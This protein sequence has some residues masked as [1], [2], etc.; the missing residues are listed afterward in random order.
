M[1]AMEEKILK[2]GEVFPGNILKV[3]SFLNHRIDVEF[4]MEMGKDIAAHFASSKPDKILTVEASGIAIAIAAASVLKV[5]VVFAKKHA[6]KNMTGDLYGAKVHSYTHGNDALITVEKK[7]LSKGEKVLIIDDFLAIGNAVNGL[8]DI[9][10]QAGAET[11]GVSAAIEKG[12]QNGGDSLRSKGIDVYSL[13][14]IDSMDDGVI[15]F[16]A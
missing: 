1:K 16:R 13:A 9:C 5:P 11:V 10:T 7:Y 15:N 4:L 12:F 8:M 14:I 3:T 2:E 6:G